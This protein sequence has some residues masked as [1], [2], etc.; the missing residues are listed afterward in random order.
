MYR[1]MN[2]MSNASDSRTELQ[3]FLTEKI[4]LWTWKVVLYI[5][6]SKISMNLSAGDWTKG[7]P[8][9][10]FKKI[11][12]LQFKNIYLYSS[13]KYKQRIIIFA[14]LFPYICIYI[15]YIYIL[16]E[17]YLFHSENLFWLIHVY[18]LKELTY[19]PKKLCL[20]SLTLKCF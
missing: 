9:L 5:A 15:Y 14:D 13:T 10:T 8:F 19:T 16:F 3:I 18:K 12:I 1:A 7:L 2:L 6:K 17:Y 20:I 4:G 11:H